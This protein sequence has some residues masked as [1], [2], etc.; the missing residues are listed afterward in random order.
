MI[1]LTP[2]QLLERKKKLP[3]DVREAYSS[4][5]TANILMAIGKEAQISTEKTG[6]VADETGLL[7]LGLTHPDRFI[8]NLAKRLDID[9]GLASKIAHKIND[10]IFS[11]IRE[12]LRKIHNEKAEPVMEQL[13]KPQQM[14]GDEET[15]LPAPAKIP[16]D[17]PAPA[18]A[19]LRK[20]ASVETTAGKNIFEERSKEKVFRSKPTEKTKQFDP[21]REPL[22]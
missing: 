14:F 15:I 18:K 7:M 21:Y 17:K 22:D 3:E 2:Q 13:I 20:P 16:V 12:S 10:Q 8:S 6:I 11:K 9:K 1:K 4:V 5:N 19:D